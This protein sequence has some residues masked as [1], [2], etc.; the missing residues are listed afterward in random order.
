MAGLL[1][2]KAALITGAASGIGAAAAQRFAAEGAAVCLAD[3]DAA[4]LARVKRLLEATGARA[5]SVTADIGRRE[6]NIAMIAQA[7]AA[8]DKLDAAFLNAG[9]LGGMAGFDALTPELFDRVVRTNLYGV[10]YGLKALLPVV[11][12]GGAVVVT[13][14]TAGLF[15]LSENAA[16]SASKHGIVGLVRSAA[17][18][19]AAKRIRLN[20]IC[21]GGVATPMAGVPQSDALVAPA[22]LAMPDFRGMASPQHVAEL[23]VFLASSRASAITGACHVVDVGWTTALPTGAH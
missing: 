21:P 12:A 19:F 2:G 10:F 13:A 8:F 18:A 5:V 11:S 7:V 23:A 15:G 6:D 1:E 3:T 22:D 20:A 14:S 4:G 9:V 16:Y 17:A